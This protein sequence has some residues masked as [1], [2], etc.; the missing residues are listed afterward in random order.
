MLDSFHNQNVHRTRVIANY[1]KQQF[2]CTH[3]ILI[4]VRI[5]IL[6]RANHAISFCYQKTKAFM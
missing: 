6:L 5:F 2:K 1:I 3:K 4:F